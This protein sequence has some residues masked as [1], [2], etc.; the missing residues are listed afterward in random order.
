MADDRN[1]TVHLYV[2]AVAEEIYGRLAGYQAL[3]AKLLERVTG[4]LHAG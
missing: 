2:E 1:R 3:M 4:R